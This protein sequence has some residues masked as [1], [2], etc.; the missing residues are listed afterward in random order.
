MIFPLKYEVIA[1]RRQGI[2]NRLYF[3]RELTVGES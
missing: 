1:R 2:V 3:F